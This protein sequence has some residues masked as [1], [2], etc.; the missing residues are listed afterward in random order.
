MLL[1]SLSL[2]LKL[3]ERLL[4]NR[5]GA[6][7]IEYALIIATLSM[8]AIVGFNTLGQGISNALMTAAQ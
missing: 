6:N 3:S 1:R 7:T 4:R 2:V 5:R 8:V